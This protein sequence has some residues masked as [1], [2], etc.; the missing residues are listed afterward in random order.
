VSLLTLP[1]EVPARLIRRTLDDVGAIARVAREVPARLDAID[2]RAEAVQAQLDRAL[3]LGESIEQH[4]A[5]V[6][7]LGERMERN[8]EALVTIGERL[9]VRG[10]EVAAALPTLQR[11]IAIAEP[12]EGTVERLGRALD[13]IPG[14]RPRTA[15]STPEAPPLPGEAPPADPAT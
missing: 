12:P 5:A 8:G 2:A 6:V 4:G 15:A 7:E 14:G 11:A 13:R 9:A 3:T 10:A 1:F